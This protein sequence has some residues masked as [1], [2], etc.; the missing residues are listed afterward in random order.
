MEKILKILKNNLTYIIPVAVFIIIF[1]NNL[2]F[3]F[4][5]IDYSYLKS[6]NIVKDLQNPY[7]SL[8][9]NAP[10]QIILSA[11]NILPYYFQILTL[12][13]LIIASL[14]IKKLTKSNLAIL[15]YT[16]NPFI[17]DRI[18]IGQIGIVA[19]YLLMPIFV[20]SLTRYVKGKATIKEIALAYFISSCFSIHFLLINAITFLVFIIIYKKI[21]IKDI[22]I[23]AIITLMLNLFWLIP[24]FSGSNI[25]SEIN[26]HDENFFAPKATT[27][28]TAVSEI[29]GLWGFWRGNAY[30]S[31]YTMLPEFLS[32]ILLL[33]LPL[34]LIF[35]Y[36]KNPKK[37]K[38]AYFTLFWA[39][40]ILAVGISYAITKPI[41][42]FL[43]S[44]LPLFSGMRDSQKFASLIALAYAFLIPKITKKTI[45]KI[46]ITILIIFYTFPLIGL[47]GQMHMQPYPKE[48]SQAI[49]VLNKEN[50]T[51]RTIYLPWQK[52]LTY[53]WSEKIASDGRIS[54]PFIGI[55]SN[56][57]MI[58]S[59]KWG[60]NTNLTKNI[61]ECLSQKSIS[62]LK[63]NSVQYIIKDRCAHFPNNYSFINQ[64]EIYNKG[65]ITIYRLEGQNKIN[66]KQKPIIEEIILILTSLSAFVYLAYGTIKEIKNKKPKK[67]Q[68]K[69]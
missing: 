59:D 55:K 40:I 4:Y 23:F 16:F 60:L 5:S 45:P 65:C 58:G 9:L 33:S 21:K 11:L 51:G 20:Y 52:Y 37:E 41:F 66:K 53:N 19:A 38:T 7:S 8:I 26:V 34:I 18:M 69:P 35:S 10:F 27:G 43:F 22:A 36:F 14:Y 6:Y 3:P 2:Q 68:Q 48:Y 30:L 28:F 1:L 24:F 29:M 47:W 50:I 17:Y 42:Q 12:I 56:N 32:Y 13:C 54:A 57:I 39:G 15:I 46:L 63:N 67:A 44:N 62:C 25:I 61:S 49:N 64:S 31:T